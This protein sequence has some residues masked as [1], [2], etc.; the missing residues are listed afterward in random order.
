MLVLLVPGVLMGGSPSDA[1]V[2]GDD[3]FLA[4]MGV[5]RAIVPFL[6]WLRIWLNS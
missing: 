5:G 2:G 6:L 1:P 4:I 3:H